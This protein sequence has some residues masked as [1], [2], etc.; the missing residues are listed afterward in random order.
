MRRY[1]AVL[2]VLCLIPPA[3]HA[4]ER[5]M[6][7]LLDGRKVGSLRIDRELDGDRV[8]TR[9]VL[10]FRMTRAR[11]PMA[12][13]TELRSTESPTGDPLAFYASTRMSTQENLARDHVIASPSMA[14][15]VSGIPGSATRAARTSKF[16]S[17]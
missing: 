7:V 6:T 8:V 15:S 10:D 14:S 3:I 2:A 4:E 1:L 5:W 9:Q 11:T 17:R 13:R 16:C 12:L